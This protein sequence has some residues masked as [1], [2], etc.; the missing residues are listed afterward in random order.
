MTYILTP[1]AIQFSSVVQLC[2]ILCHPI[3]LE[4]LLL[5]IQYI[6]NI[7]EDVEKMEPYYTVEM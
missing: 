2:L 6:I 4:L 1:I 3:L 7:N 5:K